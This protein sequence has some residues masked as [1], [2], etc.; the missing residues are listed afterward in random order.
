M[1]YVLDER[2]GE[3]ASGKTIIEANGLAHHITFA[4][5]HIKQ[6]PKIEHT[7]ECSSVITGTRI[8]VA[9]PL[10]KHAPDYA[11]DVITYC[12]NNFLQLAEAYAWFNPHLTLRLTWNDELKIDLKASN[13]TWN[14]W[15]PSWPTSAHWY[16]EGRFR[17][18]MAA[19]IAHRGDI[20]VRE[21]VSEFRGMSGTAKQKTVLAETGASHRSLHDFF[22]VHKANTENIS[23]L[24]ASLKQHTRP[25]RPVDIG[26]IG[27]QHFYQLMEIAGGDPQTFTYK[28]SINV[29]NGVPRVIEFAF[30][31]HRAG[32]STARHGLSRK[33]VTGVNW[34][35]GINNPFRQLGR[36]GQGLDGILAEVR[37]NTSQPVIAALHIACPRV[38]YTDRASPRSSSKVRPR[39]TMRNKTDKSRSM[40]TDIIGM[41]REGTKKWTRTVKAEE[42]SPATRSY[43]RSR[44]I[45]ERSI[46]IKEA[47]AEIMPEAYRKVS[48][49]EE[50]PANARQIMYVAR[51]HIEQ[52]TGR[53]L[54]D[55]YFTQTILPDYLRDT[56]VDWNVV[57]DARGHFS[58]PHDGER[59]GLGTLEVRNYLA[60]L[61][62]PTH[63]VPHHKAKIETK[64]PSGNFGGILFIE[65]EGFDS[66]IEQAQIANRYDIAHM[67]TKG[68]S[69]TAARELADEMC[70]RYDVP[71]LLLHDFDKS[72]F[73]IAGTW[74]RDTRRYEFQNAIT[75][76]DLGLSLADVA[77]MGLEAEY[78]AHPKAN[79]AALIAN[80]RTNGASEAEIAF[81]FRDFDQLRS[82]RRVELNAMTS[83]QFI[84]FIER[85]LQE[86][87]I[88]KIVPEEDELS[89]AYELFARAHKVR[90]IIERESKRLN[91]KPVAQPPSDIA[92]KVREYLVQHPE[93]RWDAAVERIAE[94]ESRKQA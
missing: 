26:I 19:H 4:V 46:S 62:E 39:A 40:A 42:R 60:G 37:V 28:R 73:S 5:D 8:T 25:V 92:E 17:R 48:G 61:H 55:N 81:M 47:A 59:F 10:C 35:P 21:F 13:P 57:Y 66:H 69:V 41:V 2:Q 31:V 52:A 24:L 86:H 14:K 63:L 43:R 20:T 32:L 6:E 3:A 38:T 80:L 30:G 54:D 22:G 67:S 18:Y 72:G 50:L 82:T 87:G 77:A 1:G 23:K 7:T 64:G 79:K 94:A 12:K 89:D 9:L 70:H 44:M 65:K 56:D 71:L 93:E 84:S 76:I 49:P 16:D 85:K 29:T 36:N 53:K 78:Q 34:S 83:P 27:K 51:P 74:Q 33:L 68:M 11:S 75:V 90:Q 88:E 91:A 58:E 15:L 45:R